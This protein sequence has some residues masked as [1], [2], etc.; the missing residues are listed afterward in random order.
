VPKLQRSGPEWR[1]SSD[2]DAFVAKFGLKMKLAAE[3]FDV[4]PQGIDS[5][6]IN[7]TV[8]DSGHL[9]LADL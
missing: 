4:S 5:C 1:F 2:L 8:F 3:S 6:P 9:V 7:V